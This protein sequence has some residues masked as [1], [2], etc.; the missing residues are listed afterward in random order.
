MAAAQQ[1]AALCSCIDDIA[2]LQTGD[3]ALQRPGKGT[4]KGKGKRKVQAKA[5]A[6]TGVIGCLRVGHRRHIHLDSLFG[7]PEGARGLLL[8]LA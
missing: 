6:G 8:P 3:L 1:L 7:L 2:G 4:A 5:G